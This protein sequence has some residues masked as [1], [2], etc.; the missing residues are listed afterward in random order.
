MRRVLIAIVGAAAGLLPASAAAAAQ[1][2]TAQICQGWHTVTG[3]DGRQYTV[4]PNNWGGGGTCLKDSGGQAG[5]TVESQPVPNAGHVLAYP[6]SSIGCSWGTGA[7]C[8][9]GWTPELVSSANPQETVAMSDTGSSSD[10]WDFS[11]DLWFW[12]VGAAHPDTELMIYFDEQNL[13]VPKGA[14]QVTVGR[15]RYWYKTYMMSNASYSWRFIVLERVTPVESV[16]SIALRPILT[17]AQQHK[18]LSG[19]DD[20]QQVNAGFEESQGGSGLQLKNFSLTP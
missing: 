2:A 5:F 10:V 9:K 14:V 18:V 13:A 16:T 17:Y 7:Y 15:V 19:S 8:T 3:A 11:N 4:N 20:L 1:P 6:E 12:P